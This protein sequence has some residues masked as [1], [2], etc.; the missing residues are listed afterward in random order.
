MYKYEIE[1][2]EPHVFVEQTQRELTEILKPLD[3]VWPVKLRNFIELQE[4]SAFRHGLLI[5]AILATFVVA[6]LFLV[7]KVL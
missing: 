1:P 4:G 3:P 7:T 6:M 2:V 5:G